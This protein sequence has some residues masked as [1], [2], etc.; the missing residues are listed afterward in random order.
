MSR[1]TASAFDVEF[2]L[3]LACSRMHADRGLIDSLSRQTKNWAKV[4]RYA[5]RHGLTH[6]LCLRLEEANS[7]FASLVSE[8]VKSDIRQIVH[9]NLFLTVELLRIMRALVAENIPAIPYKGPVLAATTYGD[10]AM[11]EFCDL[12][13]LVSE[14]DIPGVLRV[15]PQLGYRAEYSL[16]PAQEAR[17]LRSTCEYNFVHE[18]SYASVEIHWQVVPPKLGLKLDFDRLWSRASRVYIG[19]SQLPVLSPEDGLLVLSVHGFKHLWNSLKWVCDVANLLRSQDELDWTYVEREAKRIGAMRVVLVA[20]CLAN[21]LCESCLPDP[22]RVRL[23]RDP[24]AASIAREIVSCYLPGNSISR[25]KARLLMLR[26][27]TGFRDRATYA[28]R[29]LFDPTTEDMIGAPERSMVAMRGQQVFRVARQA[30]VHFSK[31]RKDEI[32]E[33]P[34]L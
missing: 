4:V 30:I 32:S 25:I 1:E 16:T 6:Q 5:Q 34:E 18:L 17:Y 20:I 3:L 26:A 23:R 28:A 15:M 29:S 7:P 14:K 11:R 33:F 9:Q 22:I 24:T 13:I 21:Q 31:L 10:L 12:D 19:G 8:L 2:R 27:Y